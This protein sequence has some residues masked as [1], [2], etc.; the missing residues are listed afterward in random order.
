MPI[1]QFVRRS[2]GGG[3]LPAQLVSGIGSGDLTFHI[4]PATTWVE[5]D[6]SPLGTMGPF[7]IGID[8]FTPSV[9][10]ILCKSIDLSTGLVTVFVAVDG[11]TG[12]GYDGTPPQ[13]HVPGTSS[14]G[15][16]HVWT[17]IEADEMSQAVYDLLGGGG[18]ST[19][20][21]PI[22]TMLPFAG[23]ALTLP[24]NFLAAD[25]SAVSRTTYS[26]CMTALTI[27]TT[28]T[29]TS[30][31]A[32]ITAVSS[33]V[34]PYVGAGMQVT[35]T[36]SGGAVYTVQS[37]TSTTIVLTSGVGITAGTAGNLIVYPWGAGDGSTTFDIPDSRGR[38][39]MGAGTGIFLTPR[40]TGNYVGEETHALTDAELAAH[41]HGGATLGQSADHSHTQ[42]PDT[43]Y[44][45]PGGTFGVTATNVVQLTAFGGKVTT[46]ASNDHT[47][48]ISSD[49][50][51]TA[52]NTIHP[53]LV[54]TAMIR[55]T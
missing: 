53:V 13:A 28:G 16:E 30:A 7:S 4:A 38:S 18:G 20:F 32:T 34:T 24:A 45:N 37:T 3:A 26:A 12:R 5:E 48:G 35:L 9:E 54:A 15:V 55:V 43:D 36:N 19:G 8:R 2:H 14:S 31:G 33:G 40:L 25:G 10:K 27:A 52:H 49:G 21:V 47:H 41:S 22:G 23:T 1:P 50:S 42:S 44:Q 11:T 51:G 46:G 17:S 29:T 39:L 6:G